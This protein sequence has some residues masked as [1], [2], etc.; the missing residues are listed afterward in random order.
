MLFQSKGL[1]VKGNAWEIESNLDFP[2]L[3][4]GFLLRN[5]RGHI[6]FVENLGMVDGVM[7]VLVSEQNLE[8]C[9]VIS[10][11]WIALDDPQIRGFVY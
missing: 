6:A 11:R 3:Y 1:Q 5:G 9:C 4:S 2:I 7:S 10:W 8:G